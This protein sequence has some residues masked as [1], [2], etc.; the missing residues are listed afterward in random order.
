MSFLIAVSITE[1]TMT[2]ACAP[3]EERN[4]PLLLFRKQCYQQEYHTGKGSGKD[5]TDW[6]IL[7]LKTIRFT[8]F[9]STGCLSNS[10]NL[11]SNDFRFSTD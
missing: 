2:K 8:C 11:S 1:R 7:F 10:S 5:V 9:A 6:G 4:K 3:S